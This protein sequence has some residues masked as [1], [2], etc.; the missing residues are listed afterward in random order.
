MI[1]INKPRVAPQRLVRAGQRK[2]AS[3]C[4]AYDQCPG[5]YISGLKGFSKTDTDR[6]AQRAIYGSGPV[7]SLLVEA[8]QSKCCYCERKYEEPRHLAIEHFRPRT[9]VRQSI[10]HAAERPGYYWL[11]YDWNNLLLSCGECN[12]DYKGIFF[13]L[14]NPGSRARSHHD[15]YR[16]E[17]PLLINPASVEPRRH[18]VFQD[19]TPTSLTRKGKI[20]LEVIGLRR[21]TLRDARLTYLAKLRR[22]LDIVE[23][24]QDN[25]AILRLSEIAQR[26][27]AFIDSA[28]LADAP[29]SSMAMDYLN[30]YPA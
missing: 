20:T 29:F 6:R 22:N 24:A 7:K 10:R 15:N 27:Q 5:D 17:R 19:E 28:I 8:H 23:V 25:P 12:G 2:T 21:T 4:A 26:S 16:V 14:S 18:I 13:P 3:E 9:A 30:K 1:R 11:A